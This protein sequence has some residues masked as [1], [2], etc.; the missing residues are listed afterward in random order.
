MYFF[1]LRC[2]DI[3]EFHSVSEKCELLY[4][5]GPR[6]NSLELISIFDKYNFYIFC[7]RH[8]VTAVRAEIETREGRT[9]SETT[10]G[11]FGNLFLKMM[12]GVLATTRRRRQIARWSR[13]NRSCR[14]W[15]GQGRTL[16]CICKGFTHLPA[17]R[18]RQRR[19]IAFRLKKLSC[20]P[21]RSY[22]A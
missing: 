3:S 2:V 15:W 10:R 13:P 20:L 4:R 12:S 17:R 14:R 21:S 16:Y 22:R 7:T 6:Q 1:P 11:V 19:P 18:A 5:G 9:E 8:S